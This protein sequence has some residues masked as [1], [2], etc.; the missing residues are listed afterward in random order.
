MVIVV[1][2]TCLISQVWD[3]NSKLI[4]MLTAE[5]EKGRIKVDNYWETEIYNKMQ[6]VCLGEIQHGEHLLQRNFVIK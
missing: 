4:L 2:S 6:V 5:M 1:V 3:N